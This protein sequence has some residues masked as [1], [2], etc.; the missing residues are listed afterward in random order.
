[1]E[2]VTILDIIVLFVDAFF[3]RKRSIIV[4]ELGGEI[5]L[6]FLLLLKMTNRDYQGES[7]ELVFFLFELINLALKLK[8]D[9]V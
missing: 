2:K 1:M 6:A 7:H 8:N 4:S 9:D 3:A 5:R